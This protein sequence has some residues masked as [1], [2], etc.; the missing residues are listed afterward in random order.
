[1]CIR[2]WKK[3]RF[4]HYRQPICCYKH[5]HPITINGMMYYFLSV[6][7]PMQEALLP[8]YF[9]G[10]GIYQRNKTLEFSDFPDKYSTLT[11]RICDLLNAKQRR[12]FQLTALQF[13]TTLSP[14]FYKQQSR[15]LNSHPESL[16]WLILYLSCIRYPRLCSIKAHLL[17][18]LLLLPTNEHLL[19]FPPTA[20]RWESAVVWQ[21]DLPAELIPPL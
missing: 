6:T 8:G 5:N 1:M 15:K 19:L 17:L 16:F 20:D 4:S 13:L 9:S 18:L 2:K 14:L 7:R 3:L 11:W 10:R 21:S 12:G